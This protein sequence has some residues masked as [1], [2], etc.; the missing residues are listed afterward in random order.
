MNSR[1][2]KS[3]KP[4]RGPEPAKRKAAHTTPLDAN[5]W[6]EG[7]VESF[8]GISKDFERSPQGEL[9]ERE[10]FDWKPVAR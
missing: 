2:G 1:K 8:A 6:P 4:T 3:S 10:T 7:Y 9:E 5:G